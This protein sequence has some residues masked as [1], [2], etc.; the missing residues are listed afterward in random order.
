MTLF[1]T[2]NSID[3][4]GPGICERELKLVKMKNPMQAKMMEW[5]GTKS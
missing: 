1:D 3:T 2:L 4:N 5:G